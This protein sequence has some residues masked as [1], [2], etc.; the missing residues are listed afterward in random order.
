MPVL[1][2]WASANQWYTKLFISAAIKRK[3]Y[4]IVKYNQYFECNYILYEKIRNVLA[5]NCST[6]CNIYV[7]WCAAESMEANITDSRV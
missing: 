7:L 5:N 4:E 2:L 6:Y 3:T 1:V